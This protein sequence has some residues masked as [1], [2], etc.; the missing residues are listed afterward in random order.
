MKEKQVSITTQ[1]Y[2]HLYI[3]SMQKYLVGNV[4][5]VHDGTC[6]VMPL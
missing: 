6:I 1:Q 5:E 3:I 4:A 2:T